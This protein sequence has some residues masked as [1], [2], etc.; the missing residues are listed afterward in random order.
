MYSNQ[1][2]TL[3]LDGMPTVKDLSENKSS[4]TGLGQQQSCRSMH[5]HNYSI[6]EGAIEEESNDYSPKGKQLQ[7]YQ[8]K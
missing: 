8:Y 6:E 5:T 2:K 7:T 1:K 3:R 4:L